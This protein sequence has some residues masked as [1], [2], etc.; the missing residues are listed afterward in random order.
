VKLLQIVGANPDSLDLKD[1]RAVSC[2]HGL[3]LVSGSNIPILR[4]TSVSKD[5]IR[6]DLRY[7]LAFEGSSN[8]LGD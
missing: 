8:L 6:G 7:G 4:F 5:Y 3:T 2:T 1:H